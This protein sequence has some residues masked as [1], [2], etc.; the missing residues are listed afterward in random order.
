MSLKQGQKIYPERVSEKNLQKIFQRIE[1][2]PILEDEVLF[3]TAL[4]V[5]EQ[6]CKL[7]IENDRFIISKADIV[8]FT[9]PSIKIKQ[10][11]TL[12]AVSFTSQV[13]SY[14]LENSIPVIFLT[15]TGNYKGRLIA[16]GYHDIKFIEKQLL[17]KNDK[18][19]S[20]R[21]S[22]A[23]IAGKLRNYCSLIEK[24]FKNFRIEK[25]RIYEHS[26]SLY[27]S[28]N[29]DELRGFEGISAATY[30]GIIKNEFEHF[31]FNKRVKR[32]PTDIVNSLLSFGYTILYSN[33]ISILILNNLN[34][35]I[36][37]FHEM[38]P[39]HASLASDLME[40]FRAWA[41]DR[42]IF[43]A[44]R[45][46]EF[47]TED[48]TIGDNKCFYLKQESKKKFISMIESN[49]NEMF[50][51]KE[52]G[53]NVTLKRLIDLQAKKLLKVINGQEK[54]YIPMLF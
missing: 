43:K 40:E 35:Y 30:F 36:G 24:E 9:I 5:S 10:I 49:M 22:K 8:L 51:H 20:I 41:I 27:K 42:V 17:F 19:K 12:G 18:Q 26:I 23:F 11:I 28:K 50:L 53:F 14:C 6:G 21:T 39:N 3:L 48:F 7:S 16:D 1:E 32:P 52:T 54:D 45:N 13:I 46:N 37:I 38:S 29:E 44:L 2:K 33:V 47:T 15:Q 31:G 4:Y 34:P 25:N